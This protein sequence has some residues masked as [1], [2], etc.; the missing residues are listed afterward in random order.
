MGVSNTQLDGFLNSV[1]DALQ[2]KNYLPPN[3]DKSKTIGLMKTALDQLCP[4][5]LEPE[6]LLDPDFKKKLGVIMIHTADMQNNPNMN[7]KPAFMQKLVTEL[8]NLV[9]N[10]KNQPADKQEEQLF[11]FLK[12]LNDLKPDPKKRL[13]DEQLKDIAKD[14]VDNVLAKKFGKKDKKGKETDSAA[15]P[16]A[17]EMTNREAYDGKDPTKE[18]SIVAVML[19]RKPNTSGIV[20]QGSGVGG[21]TSSQTA[22]ESIT[23]DTTKTDP[24]GKEAKVEANLVS[25][26]DTLE[27]ALEGIKVP[28]GPP[29]LL[30]PGVPK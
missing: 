21:D 15:G 25:L 10:P 5:G 2:S 14:V 3:A 9:L 26:G 23:L 7:N 18:D 28:S 27:D 22:F 16:S 24:L 8:A 13:S 11:T 17:E 12:L 4:E 29:R 1:F 20:A 19:V 6:K 30:P